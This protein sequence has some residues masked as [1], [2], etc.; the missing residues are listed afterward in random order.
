MRVQIN[1]AGAEEEAPRT[2]APQRL[3]CPLA[4]KSPET[5][6]KTPALTLLECYGLTMGPYGLCL[7]VPRSA[8]DRTEHKAMKQL[9]RGLL[10]RAAVNAHLQNFRYTMMRPQCLPKRP[11]Q[12]LLH[13]IHLERTERT[14]EV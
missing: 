4:E 14:A 13:W 11:L 3:C 5:R 2:S 1:P 7:A 8:C 12:H 10:A 9:S 6:Q